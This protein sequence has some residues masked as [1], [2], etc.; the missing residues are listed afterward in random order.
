MNEM[1]QQMLEQAQLVRELRA[2]LR[3]SELDATCPT[4]T[5]LPLALGH[6]HLESSSASR[7]TCDFPSLSTRPSSHRVSDVET[8][9]ET[10]RRER[11]EQR[12]MLRQA[13]RQA[14]QNAQHVP[15]QF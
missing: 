13:R 15:F 5:A 14:R 3:Q 10:L 12:L 1:G 7:A 6:P 4:T 11:Q 8:D 2:L 9:L